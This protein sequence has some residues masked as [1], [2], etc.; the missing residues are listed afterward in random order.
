MI[1]PD[2]KV[3]SE[4]GAAAV[5]EVE[6]EIRDFIRNDISFLRR[7][8]GEAP[9]LDAA[10]SPTQQMNSLVQ[11]VA[12]ASIAEIDSLMTELENL[13]D[14]L[15]SEGERVQREIAGY[16]QLSEAAMKSTRL[17]SENVQ[18]WKRSVN[19]PRHN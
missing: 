6:A 4:E 15:H 8:A 17:I 14:Y 7:P 3:E 9:P 1:R 16:A 13:R 19:G 12:G 5:Q 2:A 18:Q 11:R 10:A